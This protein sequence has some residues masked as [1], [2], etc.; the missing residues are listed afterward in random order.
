MRFLSVKGPEL[1]SKYIGE[2]EAGVRKVGPS[3]RWSP[4]LQLSVRK[5]K[6]TLLVL[7]NVL[8]IRLC[9]WSCGG[10]SYVKDPE[11]CHIASFAKCVE[12]YLSGQRQLHLLWSSSTK[13]RCLFGAF[14]L[15]FSLFPS[16]YTLQISSHWFDRWTP[17]GEATGYC[18]FVVFATWTKLVGDVPTALAKLY[19]IRLWHQSVEAC[20][21]GDYTF[22]MKCFALE[23]FCGLLSSACG[24]DSFKPDVARAL[25]RLACDSWLYW[26]HWSCG[27]PDAVLS[28]WRLHLRCHEKWRHE[29][30]TQCGILSS[31]KNSEPFSD[32]GRSHASLRSKIE[33]ESSWSSPL[34]QCNSLDSRSD[35]L[36][37]SAIQLV[38]VENGLPKNR[39]TWGCCNRQTGHG[40]SCIDETRS[41]R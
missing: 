8:S 1:L 26:C 5:F 36:R 38:R 18:W 21:C 4:F 32:S 33:A 2:S 17:T 37:R 7:S 23:N 14:P 20:V 12:R 30:V 39:T 15:H 28:W 19:H 29:I 13:S 41:L 27:Q 11:K 35:S 16:I 34:F 9:L 22:G 3:Y 24:H 10:F 40:R 31:R 6:T 25:A